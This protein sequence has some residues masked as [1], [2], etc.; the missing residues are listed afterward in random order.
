MVE[1][2]LSYH[3]GDVELT[4]VLVDGSDGVP[5]PGVL[6]AHEAPGRDDRMT[7]WARRLAGRGYV[8]L[9]LDMYGLP[10]SVEESM[11]RH[12]AL[13]ATPGL[14]LARA[15][16]ALDV[17]AERREVDA[18]RMAAIGFCQGG[19]VAMELARARAGIRC[20]I[21]FHPGL[22]RA[23]GSGPGPIE[24]K[25]LMMVGERDPV[26]PVADRLAFADEMEAAGADWQLHVFGGVGHTFTNPA[27]DALG[28]P[29]FGYN[30]RAERRAWAMAYALLD[31][32][33]ALGE[34][35]A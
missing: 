4:G 13:M 16:A 21:G 19:V 11:A 22:T 6:V 8:A 33:F 27:I 5:A 26:V 7:E 9:A 23:A 30:A 12:E 14:M 15:R 32:S 24:A 17:L 10:F 34:G 29:G 3:A 35:S 18:N 28:I 2:E 1:R 20:A 31:E 25:V